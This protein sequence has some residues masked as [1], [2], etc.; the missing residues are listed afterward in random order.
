[1]SHESNNFHLLLI[2]CLQVFYNWHSRLLK[3]E[4]PVSR[5][6]MSV[7]WFNAVILFTCLN[8]TVQY[9]Y[10]C[11]HVSLVRCILWLECTLLCQRER[12][13][14]DLWWHPVSGTRCSVSVLAHTVD[15][16]ILRQH[17]EISRALPFV[18]I[19]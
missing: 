9:I 15:L 10:T 2:S 5:G 1:M 19:T 18:S 4:S 17:I 13:C 6:T 8:C 7:Q 12:E 14:K 3:H 16:Y 11:T